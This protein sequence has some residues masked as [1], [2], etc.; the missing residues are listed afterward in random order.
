M[1]LRIH[2][3][4]PFLAKKIIFFL[5][6]GAPTP[7]PFPGRPHYLLDPPLCPLNNS[8]LWLRGCFNGIPNPKTIADWISS[9][10]Y[11][12]NSHQLHIRQ[13]PL[14]APC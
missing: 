11:F 3:N 2:Q 5:G 4:M 7:Y 9:H 10:S 14:A 12:A 1:P 8:S 6:R 13:R